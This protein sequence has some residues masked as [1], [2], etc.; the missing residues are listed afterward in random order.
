MNRIALGIAL[1]PMFVFASA[2][3]FGDEW[4]TE[5]GTDGNHLITSCKSAVQKFDEPSREF[6]KQEVHNIGFCLGFVSG[7]AD[8]AQDDANLTGTTRDQLVRVVHKYLDDHPEELSKGAAWL[9]R[10]ALVKA[11]PKARGAK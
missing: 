1:L 3:A 8:S 10:H 2:T 6:T 11:F 4:A 7:I 5:F 9:V